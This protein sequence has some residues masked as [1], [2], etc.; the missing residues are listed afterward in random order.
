MKLYLKMLAVSVSA[1]LTAVGGYRLF[2]CRDISESVPS[3]A[4]VGNSSGRIAEIQKALLEAGYYEGD[5]TGVPDEALYYAI[6][7]FRAGAGLSESNR[8][9]PEVLFLLG[10][11]IN[12]DE[13]SSYEADRLIASAVD[14]V[15]PDAGYLVKV[16][17]A[18]V[19]IKRTASPGFPDNAAAVIFSCG[20]LSDVYVH[21]FSAEP[22][23]DA[24]SAVR[25]ARIGM[26]PCPEAM[27]FYRSDRADAVL[28]RKSVL[29]R[30]GKYCFA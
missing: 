4:P 15:C 7:E 2:F 20:Q 29:F 17:L 30:S 27:Y 18:G 16:A 22:S 26:S 19:I 3:S 9:S 23:D 24:F 11:P 10:I 25:D 12:A 8:L 21:D 1:V 14:A 5:I 13:T 28:R 6:A